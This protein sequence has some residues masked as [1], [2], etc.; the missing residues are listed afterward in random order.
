MIRFLSR[1]AAPLT[2]AALMAAAPAAQALAEMAR[3]IKAEGGGTLILNSGYRSFSYQ[4]FLYQRMVAN[5]GK[6]AAEKRVARPGFSEH[7]LG[8][9]ADV[10]AVGQGCVIRACFGSTR[11][12]KWL[13]N[14]AH[15]FG[16]IVRY[17]K[18]QTEI[19]GYNYE[20]W[21]LRFVGVELATEMNRLQVKTL[22]HFWQLP[23][24]PTYP[25]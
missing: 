17:Q 1:F 2:V 16:F 12:G 11:A 9:A 18:N 6:T 21:H 13:A 5:V 19:T 23:A 7:Q 8:L 25:K 3:T 15:R 4:K 22:E 10:S 14:N 24:S 20:P